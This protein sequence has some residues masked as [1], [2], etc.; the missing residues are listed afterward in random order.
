LKIKGKEKIIILKL[1]F[2]KQQKNPIAGIFS[3][4]LLLDFLPLILT[5]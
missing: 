3:G 4:H 2:F 5:Y 1:E